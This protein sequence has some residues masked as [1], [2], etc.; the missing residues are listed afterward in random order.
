MQTEKGFCGADPKQSPQKQRW[1]MC[2]AAGLLHQF[3][4]TASCMDEPF[5]SLGF[6]QLRRPV[7][8]LVA[9]GSTQSMQPSAN[10]ADRLR[11]S[12]SFSFSFSHFPRCY[13]RRLEF[14]WRMR[15]AF[16]SITAQISFTVN[17]HLCSNQIWVM[18]SCIMLV[19][20][21]GKITDK[22]ASRWRV[23]C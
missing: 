13:G 4:K 16:Q 5:P 21:P 23:T 8:Q 6:R 10:A 22:L 17:Q 15:E 1:R 12:F 18:S 2:D 7:T 19:N 3:L 20:A 11:L 14:M 9:Q